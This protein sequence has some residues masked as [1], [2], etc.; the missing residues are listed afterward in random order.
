MFRVKLQDLHCSL[1]V[2]NN[3]TTLPLYVIYVMQ[4]SFSDAS[5]C[6]IGIGCSAYSIHTKL[7]IQ[8]G[9]GYAFVLAIIA[10]P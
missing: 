1:N 5:C 6:E 3:I 2:F 9:K 4:R 10:S 7:V 8:V